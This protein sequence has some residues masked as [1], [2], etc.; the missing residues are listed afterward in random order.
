M[1]RRRGRPALG[2]RKLTPIN[3]LFTPEQRA[4]L[5]GR[6]DSAGAVTVAAVV[7]QL[8]QQAIDA[9]R[10]QQEASA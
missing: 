2:D 8:V 4:W 9:E 5:E 10:Q 3:L 7:R 6:A 1:A